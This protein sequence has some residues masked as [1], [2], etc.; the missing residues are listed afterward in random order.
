MEQQ[1][2]DLG[3]RRQGAG[4]SKAFQ[5]YTEQKVWTSVTEKEKDRK[6]SLMGP[7]YIK[8][9]SFRNTPHA[10]AKAT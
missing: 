7:E 3:N 4:K 1:Q 8:I 6:Q 2:S 5:K 9:K 10:T